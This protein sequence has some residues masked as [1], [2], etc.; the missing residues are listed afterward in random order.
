MAGMPADETVALYL[1][2]RDG[3]RPGIGP[4]AIVAIGFAL[5]EEDGEP[6]GL[7]RVLV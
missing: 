7:M 6:A 1:R 5:G 3:T 2:A 4:T